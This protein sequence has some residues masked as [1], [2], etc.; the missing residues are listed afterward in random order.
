MPAIASTYKPA[1]APASSSSEQIEPNN[2]K[3]R[4]HIDNLWIKNDIELK[5]RDVGDK[6]KSGCLYK[7]YSVSDGNVQGRERER[8]K[9]DEKKFRFCFIVAEMQSKIQVT[10]TSPSMWRGGEI[11]RWNEPP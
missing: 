1:L 7:K 6:R 5:V 2:N 10:M 4:A 8:G 3:E 11:A 9:K